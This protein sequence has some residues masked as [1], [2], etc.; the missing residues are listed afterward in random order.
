[1]NQP[2]NN[3]PGGG[4]EA[5]FLAGSA[6]YPAP[7]ICLERGSSSFAARALDLIC[8]IGRGQRGLLV[9][10]PGLGKT[11]LLQEVCRAVAKGYPEMQ[12]YCL[13][14]DERPEEVTDFRRNASGAVYASSLDQP[15][16]QHQAVV[17]EMMPRAFAAAAAGQHVLI[18][19][20]SL[21]RLTRAF[22]TQNLDKGRTLSGGLSA[23][24]LTLPRKIF[25]A[26]R[27]VEGQGSITIL[28]TILVD[29]GS[30]MDSI[31]FEEF[32]GTGNMELVLSKELAQQRIYPAL[33]L[34]KSSTRREELFFSDSENVSRQA[35]RAYLS[36]N[37]SEPVA[38][39]KN[40]QKLIDR[41]PTNRELLAH[42]A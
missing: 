25:G 30:L 16:E 5:S 41:F 6:L 7:Q 24:A 10:S 26:A 40:L 38:A 33:D 2:F 20:D 14:I 1:M 35:L 31:I 17:A 18:L 21:T 29:T 34:F 9:A 19:L 32:K 27:N 12:I 39:M 23:S 13:L 22:Q 3:P 28:A 11:T 15:A 8:P 4:A 42:F 36:G 37:R